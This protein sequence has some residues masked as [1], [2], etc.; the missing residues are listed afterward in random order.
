MVKFPSL[1]P[2]GARH[3][4]RG[5]PRRPFAA[6]LLIMLTLGALLAAQL[7]PVAAQSA[8][9][10][11]EN[12]WLRIQN[13]GGVPSTI[14]VTFYDGAGNRVA[15]DGCPKAN[16]CGTVAP[17]VGWSFFQ[18]GFDAVPVGYRGSALVKSDQPFVGLLARDA[19]KGGLFQVDGD[20]L[21][22][23]RGTPGLA[24]PIVQNTDAWV[25][26]ISVQNTSENADACVEIRYWAEGQAT[27]TAIDPPSPGTGCPQ[28]GARLAPLASI[29]R[30]EHS[31]P[32]PFGFDGAALVRTYSTASGTPAQNQT[33]SGTVNTRERNGPG[34][35]EK[36]G[37]ASDEQARVVALPL[38][39]RN[40]S[41]GGQ[42]WNTRFR[43]MNAAPGVPNE[44]SLLY[45]GTDDAGGRIEIEHKVSV[46]SSLTCDQRASG[47]SGCLP[48][49]RDLPPTF[50]GSVRLQSVEP[51]AVL[52]QRSSSSG[53]FSDYRGFT[54]TEAARQVVLPV[55]DKNY[56]PFGDVRGWNSWFRVMSYDGSPAHV[57]VVYYSRSVPG[58]QLRDAFSASGA[59]TVFQQTDGNLPDGWVGSAIVISDQPLIVLVG[60]ENDVFQGDTS[61]LYNGVGFD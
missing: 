13:V 17:G 18:Q 42:T 8:S 58:G 45:E 27:A 36:R 48:G 26:R 50:S 1:G 54:V 49:D 16:S 28:G 30:D 56:G 24:F 44:V 2:V 10:G 29:V 59:V 4:R 12:S 31:L 39:E 23:G 7:P 20:T 3:G 25:S 60:V 38:V 53:S 11:D 52:A 51:I 15:S 33:L 32:V 6:L 37:V 21:R 40:I 14:D 5:L 34:L 35:G 55:L 19:F 9:L 46:V 47:A 61:M 43:I 41:A 57:R 22:L